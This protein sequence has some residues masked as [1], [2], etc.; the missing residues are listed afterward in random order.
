[1]AI[2][3]MRTLTSP[4]NLAKTGVEEVSN[5]LPELSWHLRTL[6]SEVYMT[7]VPRVCRP[8]RV[9]PSEGERG[10]E[11]AEEGG[12]GSRTSVTSVAP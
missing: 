10:V 9:S 8:G 12:V 1:M 2:L 5:Q 3:S 11:S 6:H 4:G 7:S